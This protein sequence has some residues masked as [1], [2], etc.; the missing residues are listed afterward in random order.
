MHNFS[1]VN[2][3]NRIRRFDQTCP[4]KE[5][6]SQNPFVFFIS[7]QRKDMDTDN[8]DLSWFDKDLEDFDVLDDVGEEKLDE[9]NT[10]SKIL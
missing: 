1:I 8:S 9:D 6:D 7:D 5:E 3:K 4:F 10:T 2:T